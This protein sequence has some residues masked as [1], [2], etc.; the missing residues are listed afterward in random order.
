ML[1]KVIQKSFATAKILKKDSNQ[2]LELGKYAKDFLKKGDPSPA[3]R[4]Y[5]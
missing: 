3:V 4:S 5:I 2:A 1:S